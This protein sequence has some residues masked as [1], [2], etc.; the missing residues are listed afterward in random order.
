MDTELFRSEA[1]SHRTQAPLGSIRIATPVPLRLWTVASIVTGFTIIIW[2]FVGHYTRREHVAGILVPKAGLIDITARTAGVIE[3]IEVFEG[4]SIKAG[5]VLVTLSSERVTESYG[6][7]G[8]VVS[9]EL[10]NQHTKLLEDIADS[11]RLADEQA[12]GIRTQIQMLQGQVATLDE[13]IALKKR[14][15]GSDEKLLDKI[16]PLGTN[17]Y[18]SEY[19][20]QQQQSQ[21]YDTNA[22][23]SSLSRQRLEVLQQW[24]SLRNQLDLLPLTTRAKQNDLRRQL[25]QNQQQLAQNEADRSLVLRS[26]QDGTVSAL[27]VKRG[28]AVKLGQAILALVPQGSPLQAQLLVPSRAAGFIQPGHSVAL[29]YQAFPYQ[30]FGVQIGTVSQ[31]SHSALTPSEITDLLGQQPPQEPL[32]RVQVVLPLQSITTYEHNEPLKPGMAVDADML[33]DRRRLIEWIFE[34]LYGLRRR[35]EI[36]K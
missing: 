27:I 25:A 15:L 34:P 19:Q 12:Q 24:N 8:A 31:V 28:Q 9:D 33:M 3:R 35:G 30:K 18:V 17:G 36:N 13:Q 16:R 11:S 23:I 20:I 4:Q 21:V 6:D 29:R 14:Q 7:T 32:Y 10:K 2:L 1:I 5:D 26:P 22:Q